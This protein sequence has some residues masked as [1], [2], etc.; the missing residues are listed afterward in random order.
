MSAKGEKIVGN[1]PV[2]IGHSGGAASYSTSLLDA[3]N[4]N[5]SALVNSSP[6]GLV[7]MSPAPYPSRHDDPSVN[8][9]H[10]SGIAFSAGASIGGPSSSGLSAI[11]SAKI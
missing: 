9:F 7:R 6:S 11:K 10:S 8:R 3:S 1:S 2:F 5:L 4:S